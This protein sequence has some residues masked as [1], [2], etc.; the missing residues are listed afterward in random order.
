MNYK[1]LSEQVN[2]LA[3]PQRSDTFVRAFR[4]GVRQGDFRAIY[5]TGERFMMP[6][7]YSRRGG[8]DSYQKDTREMLFE[9]TPEFEEWFNNIN[10]E[11]AVARRGGSLKATVE[12]IEAGLV[13]FEEL[14]K[15]TQKK[16]QASHDKGR[17]LGQSHSKRPSR[18]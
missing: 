17:Q 15:Q 11:L 13:D 14:A 4:E 8:G 16:M 1:R 6:K 7:V 9:Y 5:L 3:N 2:E 18:K 12:N 10:K